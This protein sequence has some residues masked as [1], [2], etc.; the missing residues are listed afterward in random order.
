M[1]RHQ[2]GGRLHHVGLQRLGG[3]A[4]G[5]ADQG[6]REAG[7]AFQP[8]DGERERLGA[9]AQ[10]APVSLAQRRT[11]DGEDP[12]APVR[13]EHPAHQ[14]DQQQAGGE[15]RDRHRRRH[16]ALV[17]H[18]E[19]A[20]GGDGAHA[21][22]LQRPGA[23][24]EGRQQALGAAPHDQVGAG[25]AHPVIAHRE[26]EGGGVA[27]VARDAREARVEHQD[28]DGEA[29]LV[30]AAADASGRHGAIC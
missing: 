23:L 24:D 26:R 1:G 20:V 9:P 4:R 3:E 11:V 5:V 10:P 8:E 16:L 6:L 25:A 22:A 13:A 18:E 17:L 27:H 28:A 12:D 29:I 2:V 30:E 14:R 21:L 19:A 15:D 7:I